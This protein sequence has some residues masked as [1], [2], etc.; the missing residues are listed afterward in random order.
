VKEEIHNKVASSPLL[1][2]DLEDLLPDG[3]RILYDLKNNLY[4]GIIL[5]EKEFRA[6]LKENDWSVYE[7]KHVAIYCSVDAI[8]PNWAFMLLTTEIA[9]FARTIVYGTLETLND[10]IIKQAIR[11]LDPEQFRDKKIVIKGCSKK[12]VPV[13]AFIEIVFLLQPIAASIMYG[14]PCSTVPVFKRPK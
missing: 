5:R 14:E 3:E 7:G 2:I 12:D 13:S 8:I 6:F 1:T 10:E 11:K 4:Q 9:P